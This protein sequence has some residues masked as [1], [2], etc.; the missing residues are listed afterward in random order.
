M[1]IIPIIQTNTVLVTSQIALANEFIRFVTVTPQILKIAVENIPKNTKNIKILLFKIYSK[2]CSGLSQKGRPS[3]LNTQ[4]DE[5]K[6]H[7]T[8][9]KINTITA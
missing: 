1:T 5:P 2:Y 7:G 6:V 3:E 4:A 8:N 9:E